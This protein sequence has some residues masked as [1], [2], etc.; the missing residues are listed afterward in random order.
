MFVSSYKDTHLPNM[1]KD[2][3]TLSLPK[4]TFDNIMMSSNIYSLFTFL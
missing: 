4:K 2:Y 3:N 1:H